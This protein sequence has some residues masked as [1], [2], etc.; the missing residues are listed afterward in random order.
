MALVW[1]SDP[2]EFTLPLRWLG[3]LP[4]TPLTGRAWT[5]H[6]DGCAGRPGTRVA[7]LPD[8]ALLAGCC[9]C[10]SAAALRRLETTVTLWRLTAPEHLDELEW[11]PSSGI[12]HWVPDWH[13]LLP[14]SE[15]E[16]NY[17]LGLQEEARSLTGALRELGPGVAEEFDAAAAR[18]TAG[19]RRQA[20]TR[21]DAATA[22]TPGPQA[23]PVAVEWDGL[24]LL[25]LDRP[26]RT[27][28]L[29]VHV[30]VDA[31]TAAAVMMVEPQ[32]LAAYLN[33]NALTRSYDRRQDRWADTPAYPGV[34]SLADLDP[35]IWRSEQTWQ[36]A[37][38]AH[39]P[40]GSHPDGL[41]RLLAAVHAIVNPSTAAP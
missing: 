10:A 39:T 14:E 19:L 12:V 21:L 9:V 20:L 27:R 7:D 38:A 33:E 37:L 15:R 17:L 31:A 2:D 1:E 32:D 25:K 16:R 23:V 6:R 34:T 26:R 36:L 3:P 40:S 4:V 18:W 41:A 30:S 11:A 13:R 22:Y 35:R 5:V 8:G 29:A 28:P 24:G